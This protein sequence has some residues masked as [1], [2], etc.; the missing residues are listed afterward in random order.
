[1]PTFALA[2]RLVA[3]RGPHDPR[4]HARG[5][6]A[7][8]TSAPPDAKGLATGAIVARHVLRNAL[9]PMVTVIGLQAGYLLGG[10]VVV[11]RLFAWPGV[12]DLMVNAVGA[13]DYTL[14]QTITILFV[15]GFLLINLAVDVLYVLMI[16][17]SAVPDPDRR[18]RR[19]RPAP[20]RGGRRP[21]ARLPHPGC[22]RSVGG[23]V[24]AQRARP[25]RRPRTGVRRP[26]AGD[27]S[28]RDATSSPVSSWGRASPSRRRS[29]RWSSQGA[30]GRPWD[31]S[32]ATPADGPTQCS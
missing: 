15:L 24:R 4:G 11:E 18:V 13:R 1:M 8:T 30:S 32:R 12:G 3:A 7:R 25:S 28:D 2:A 31:S 5:A 10:S 14:V 6:G 23:P 21:A 16:P 17:G 22:L 20:A 19:R 29:S 26:L 27:R 9:I